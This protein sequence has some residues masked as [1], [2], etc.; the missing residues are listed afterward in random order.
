[1]ISSRTT[2]NTGAEFVKVSGAS[3]AE[4]AGSA[5]EGRN[6]EFTVDG[7]A[8]V[9]SSNTVTSAIGGV[10]LTFTALTSAGPVTVDVEPPGASTS[11]I[12]A[13]VQAFVKLYNTTVAA[14]EKQLATR[15]PTKPTTAAERGAGTLFGDLE[16]GGLL[17]SMRQ[18]NVRTDRG[19]DR[20]TVEP[21]G[22]RHQHRRRLGCRR[23]LHRHPRRAA[24]GQ[25]READRSGAREPDGSPGTCS[26]SGRRASRSR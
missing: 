8:G 26:R 22:H 6:A 16:L 21:V 3:L 9:S 4:V 25:L 11:A 18:T 7:V 20:R 24:D 12:E 23:Y 14:I 13:Q 1:M 10:T 15:P 5:V 17:N 2:G 19:P